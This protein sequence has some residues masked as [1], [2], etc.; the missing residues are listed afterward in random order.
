VLISNLRPYMKN[1]FVQCIVL[2]KE[3]VYPT[4]DGNRV[5][6][7]LVAD[8]TGSAILSV[9][10]E[11]GDQIKP[12]DVLFILSGYTTLHQGMLSLQRGKDHGKIEKVGEFLLSYNE[13][14][15]MSKYTWEEHANGGWTAHPP[16]DSTLQPMKMR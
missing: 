8:Y 15:N 14:P 13:Q 4:K 5:T 16:P 9:W 12:S 3:R 7:F 6:Q 2:E 11:L 10:D 1:I